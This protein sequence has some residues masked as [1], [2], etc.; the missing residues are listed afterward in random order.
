M[1]VITSPAYHHVQLD[2][3][4]Y[5]NM[6]ACVQYGQ[7]SHPTHSITA[8]DS[9]VC[10]FLSSFRRIMYTHLHTVNHTV[11]SVQILTQAETI[12]GRVVHTKSCIQDRHGPHCKGAS[13][14]CE[15]VLDGTADDRKVSE[16][17]DRYWVEGIARYSEFRS[18]VTRPNRAPSTPVGGM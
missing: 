1:Y 6:P 8:N 9:V 12:T 15:A 16:V 3:S 2:T 18:Q 5:Q 11:I 17:G 7:T 13:I 4:C 10:F 14:D